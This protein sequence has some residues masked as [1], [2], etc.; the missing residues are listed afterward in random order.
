MIPEN[1]LEIRIDN[2]NKL[3]IYYYDNQDICEALI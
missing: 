2:L 1:E 3:G